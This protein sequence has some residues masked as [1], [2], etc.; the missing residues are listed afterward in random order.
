MFIVRPSALGLHLQL[1]RAAE[2]RHLMNAVKTSPSSSCVT[3]KCRNHLQTNSSVTD[4][5][6]GLNENV[7]ESWFAMCRS[8]DKIPIMA[9]VSHC[10]QEVV[11][12]GFVCLVTFILDVTGV[13]VGLR[14]RA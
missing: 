12:H 5:R 1:W 10:K 3:E 11:C 14:E 4:L 9:A 6:C 13:N 8:V 2:W 7:K